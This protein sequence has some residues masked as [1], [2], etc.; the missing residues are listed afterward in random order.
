MPDCHKISFVHKYASGIQLQHVYTLFLVFFN[1]KEII[2][3]YYQENIH[4]LRGK[5]LYKQCSA[6]IKIKHA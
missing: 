3:K 5:N 2:K 1:L 4:D 6:A